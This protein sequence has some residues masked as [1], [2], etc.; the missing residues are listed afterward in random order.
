MTHYLSNDLMKDKNV[1]KI[2]LYVNLTKGQQCVTIY[3]VWWNY[4]DKRSCNSRISHPWTDR[5]NQQ[6]TNNLNK[7]NLF[8]L[9]YTDNIGTQC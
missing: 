4:S 9:R 5:H 8:S 6:Y 3:P 2:M 1:L 7:N